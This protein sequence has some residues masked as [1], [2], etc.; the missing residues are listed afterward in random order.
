MVS[1]VN[2]MKQR[3]ILDFTS[4][5]LSQVKLKLEPMLNKPELDK[6]LDLL[7]KMQL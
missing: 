3:P 4:L 2:F 5:D 6:F 7:S 1:L